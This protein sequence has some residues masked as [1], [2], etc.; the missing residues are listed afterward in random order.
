MTVE[1]DL[2]G[3]PQHAD[4]QLDGVVDRDSVDIG[5]FGFKTVTLQTVFEHILLVGQGHALF[6]RRLEIGLTRLHAQRA[7]SDLELLPLQGAVMRIQNGE[8]QKRPDDT[9]AKG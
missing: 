6:G 1:R 2:V 8:N 7:G 5:Q 3:A 4:H 9:R